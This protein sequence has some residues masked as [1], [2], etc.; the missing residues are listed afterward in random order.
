MT[1]ILWKFQPER[2]KIPKAA[3]LCVFGRFWAVL[4]VFGRGR[5]FP[6]RN[7]YISNVLFDYAHSV[8]ISARADQHSL[9]GLFE[10]SW[11]FLGGDDLFSARNCYI[12]H[13][14]F[15]YAHSVKISARANQNSQSGLLERFWVGL[16][17]FRQK[18]LHRQY[19]FWLNT[20]YKNFSPSGKAAY[21]S[22]SGQF[23]AFLGGVELFSAQ[24]CYIANV[25]FDY[26]HS[27][28]MSAR[29]D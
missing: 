20:F 3:Y 11:A 17:F 14:L 19:T 21:F 29:V 6:A 25:L 16:T 18:L 24:N 4:D 5:P 22:V 1:H 8:K 15:D 12:A 27:L 26:A 2:T 13:I 7:C 28:K 23:W 9:R 10:R